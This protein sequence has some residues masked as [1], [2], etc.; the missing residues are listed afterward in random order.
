MIYNHYDL[1]DHPVDYDSALEYTRK[2]YKTF[3]YLNINDDMISD[4]YIDKVITHAEKLEI[5]DL[6]VQA[7]MERL[8]DHVII[9]S[10]NAKGSQK[11]VA[12]INILS[13]SDDTT[14]NR[15]ASDMICKLFK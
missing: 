8:L 13:K 1:I 14:M 9:P 5:Q 12:F 3:K 10:L 15:I 4:L 6:K 2:E 7:R 11:F